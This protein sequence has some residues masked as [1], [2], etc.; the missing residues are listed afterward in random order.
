VAVLVH[1]ATQEGG[2]KH[3]FP[4][5]NLPRRDLRQPTRL[6]RQC[7]WSRGAQLPVVELTGAKVSSQTFPVHVMSAGR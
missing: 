4:G 6:P 1:D 7:T 2:I 5:R 3:H